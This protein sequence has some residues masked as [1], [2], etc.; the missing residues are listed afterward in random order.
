M[1]GSE[2]DLI[3]EIHETRKLDVGGVILF[4]Y[5]HLDEK[6]IHTLGTRVFNPKNAPKIEITREQM[7]AEPKLVV[8]RKKK[9]WWQFTK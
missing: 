6:Y 2:E 1:G 3:R 7:D 9:Q 4:D 8:P 5:A